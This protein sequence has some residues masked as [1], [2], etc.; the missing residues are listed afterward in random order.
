MHTGSNSTSPGSKKRRKAAAASPSE[1][2]RAGL[3]AEAL[4]LLQ[5]SRA[6]GESGIEALNGEEEGVQ[7]LDNNI[8]GADATIKAWRFMQVINGLHLLGCSV[9]LHSLAVADAGQAILQARVS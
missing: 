1:D 3:L 4:H 6:V 8:A 7:E 2:A 5:R 9:M